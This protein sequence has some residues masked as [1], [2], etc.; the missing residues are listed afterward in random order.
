MKIL[1]IVAHPDDE[2]LG[3]GG[4]ILKHVKNKDDV[5]VAY[6]T[7][8]ITSRRSLT[9]SNT[10]SYELSNSELSKMKKQIID[11]QS[12]AKKALKILRAKK[13]IFF[14]FPDNEMDSIPLLK[15][16]K[17][18]EKLISKE[19][20]DMVYTSH[21]KD[22]NVDHRTVF[23][24]VL[25]ACRPFAFSVKEILCFETLSST[26]WTFS[27]DF[28]PNYFVNIEKELDSKIKAMKVYKNELRKFPHPRS[29][30][31]IKISAQRWG[32]VCGFKA[33]EAFQIIRKFEK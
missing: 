11:L 22:L 28:Q 21:F 2:V 3:M 19:K 14:D 31:N 8:G 26:E 6:L 9:Y 12:D 25:T 17:K 15:I 13:S 23:E 7:T 29:L 10:S 20:P 5:T 32:T 30:E 24:A 18:V 4:T 16:I 33:A 1:I 27:Y